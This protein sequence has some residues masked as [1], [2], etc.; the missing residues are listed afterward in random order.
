MN[1][2]QLLI[3]TTVSYFVGIG[4]GYFACLYVNQMAI[5][6]GREIINRSAA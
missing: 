6:K 5:R 4:F 1:E 2:L 3:Y